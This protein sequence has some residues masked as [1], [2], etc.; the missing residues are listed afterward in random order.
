[1]PGI[2]TKLD[3]AT[4]KLSYTR[5]NVLFMASINYSRGMALLVVGD[6]VTYLFSLILTLA[7]RY[8]EIPS[9]YLLAKHI[10]S[11]VILFVIFIIV[12]ISVG[13]YDNKPA[14]IRN[15]SSGLIIQVQIINVIIGVVFFYFAPVA[16]SPKANLFIY[17]IIS[18]ALLFLWRVVM[19]PVVSSAKKQGSI[20]VGGGD[21]ITDL[22]KEIT[23]NARYNLDFKE[24]VIPTASRQET[25]DAI[26]RAV[27]ETKSSI[28][29]ADLR[30]PIIEASMPFLYSLI[31]S[32]TKIIDASK[33]YEAVFD[34][35]PLSMV[36]E[37]WLIENSNTALGNRRIYDTFKRVMDIVV[38]IVCGL[39]SLVFY[40][41]VWIAIK[42]ED[43]GP[44]FVR[45]NRTGKNGKLI[46][47]IKFRSMSG[48]DDG[49]YG[50]SG[51][52]KHIVTRVGKFIRS[53]R[54]DEL[55]QF[56]NVIKGD[57]SL[58]GPRPEFPSLGL[59]YEKEIP[60]YSV[61]YLVKPGLSGWAQIYHQAHPHH[62]VATEETRDKL[63]YD[64]YYIKN[65]SLI[66]DLKIA[67]RTLQVFLKRVGK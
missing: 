16:I 10:P 3:R 52:T 35:I 45:Q 2:F 50:F 32:G 12:G 46:E 7:I 23:G 22:F 20:M 48:N 63:S 62:A 59:I 54:I 36:G 56:W 13:L 1:M 66:L 64:L 26:S 57:L 55:P 18:T 58:I 42:I 33:L 15:K 65:R 67:L 29:V 61:R 4:L 43:S 39:I 47:I 17:F 51:D 19:F 11:F 44:I 41:F 38:S 27:N 14:I 6:L 8:G 30:N 53:S 49:K 60:Y 31:F 24:H 9:H 25:T 28:I 37:R 21:D 34:R 5:V 40:P